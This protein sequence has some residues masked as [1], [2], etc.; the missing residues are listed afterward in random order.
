MKKSFLVLSI[1]TGVIMSCNKNVGSSTVALNERVDTTAR[2]VTG[3]GPGTFVSYGQ[4]VTGSAKVYN[5]EGKYSLSLENFSTNNGPDLHVYLSK[6]TQP[7]DFIDLGKLKSTS[8]NQVYEISGIPD[9][10]QYKYALIH[11]QQ[12]NHLFGSAEFGK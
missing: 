7:T 5:K 6:G 2:L 9:F 3:V 8:G 1:L 12:Y 10:T 4:G 11:C